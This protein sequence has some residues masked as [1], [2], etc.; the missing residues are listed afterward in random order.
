[1]SADV[2]GEVSSVTTLE[3]HWKVACTSGIVMDNWWIF[4]RSDP[5]LVNDRF[6]EFPVDGLLGKGT[7]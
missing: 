7:D 1:M 4:R 3:I 2:S 6:Y 5:V